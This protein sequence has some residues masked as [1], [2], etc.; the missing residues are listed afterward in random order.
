MMETA[1][2]VISFAAMLF[3]TVLVFKSKGAKDTEL[4]PKDKDAGGKSRRTGWLTAVTA[5]FAVVTAVFAVLGFCKVIDGGERFA[6]AY[7]LAVS[8]AAAAVLFLSGRI[9]NTE[10]VKAVRF[11]VKAF[12]LCA[13][14]EI[15]LFNLNS[16][17]L[18]GGGYVERDLDFAS[19][20]ITGVDEETGVNSGTRDAVYEFTDINEPVGTITFDIIKADGGQADVK[21]DMADDTHAAYRRNI[22]SASILTGHE[23]TATIP[24]N[25]S[26]NVHKIKFTFDVDEAD[27]LLVKKITIN[28]PIMIHFSFVRVGIIWLISMCGYMLIS[29][30]VLSKSYGENKMAVRRSAYIFTAF[31]IGA[32]LWMTNSYRYYYDDHD[33]WSDFCYI[34]GNQINQELVDAFEAGQTWLLPEVN[35]NLLELDNPYD[36]SQRTDDIGDYLWDHL[37]YEGKYYSYYGIAPLLLFIPYHLLTGYYFPSV[38]AIWLF[39]CAGIIFLTK[40]YLCLMEKFFSRTRASLVLMGLFMMQ[41][42]SGIWFTFNKANFYEISQNSGFACVTAGAYLLI[43]SNVIGDGMLKKGRLMWSSVFLSLAVLCRPTL[44]VYC[45]A[46]LLFIWAGFKKLRGHCGGNVS[47]FSQKQVIEA[48]KSPGSM[49]KIRGYLSYWLCALMPFAVIGGV[50]MLYNYVRFGSVFD[51][52]IQY[53]LTINDFTQAQYHTHFVGISLWNY[54]FAFPSFSGE[55]PFFITSEVELFNP[56]GYYFVATDNALGL[57]WKALPIIAYGFA[58]RA[59]RKTENAGKGY[60]AVM[61]AATCIAAPAAIIFSIW[62]S[63]YGVRYCVDFA[64]QLL[65]GALIISFIIYNKAGANTRKHLNKV[66]AAACLV[67]LVLTFAQTV[68]WIMDGDLSNRW[69]MSLL[70]F[71]RLFEFW[72]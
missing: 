5:V 70:A 43:S 11:G 12:M 38:W 6:P 51:F 24:C 35:E 2:F 52:G 58:G 31:L 55:F 42:V 60:Y 72:R 41:L 45:V 13:M 27:S 28:K 56:N 34:N 57:V 26:G 29:S 54:L 65:M 22:A 50:Q 46:A 71:G 9:K 17:H 64:W 4:C 59:Y 36:W 63:G 47:A 3:F 16:A 15:F 61:L 39:G 21:I 37:L 68:G 18:I 44:A 8:A 66:M 10:V 67:C 20:K 23:R 53:S 32:A 40:L 30:R 14:L 33:F 19:A 49:S 69:R 7:V 48:V 62:E 1:T 25:F